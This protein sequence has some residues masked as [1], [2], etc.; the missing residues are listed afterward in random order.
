VGTALG[1]ESVNIGEYH[2]A[3][4]HAGGDALAAISVDGKLTPAVL[5][6]LQQIPDVMEVH[7]AQLD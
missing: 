5:E 6:A 1:R 7:Q 3:R 2:Q 4:L